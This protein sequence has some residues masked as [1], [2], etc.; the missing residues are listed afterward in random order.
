MIIYVLTVETGHDAQSVACLTEE[1]KVPGTIPSPA[2][3]FRFPLPLI[4][5]GQ[6]SVTGES[7]FT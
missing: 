3:Y 6:L 1:A 2:T 5:E 7:R 4:Q